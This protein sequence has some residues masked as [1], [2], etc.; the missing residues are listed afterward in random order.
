MY[1]LL[2]DVI[3]EEIEDDDRPQAVDPQLCL[4]LVDERDSFPS[5]VELSFHIGPSCLGQD[6][7]HIRNIPG[8]ELCSSRFIDILTAAS[9][10]FTAY[11]VLLQERN[12]ERPIADRYFFWIPKRISRDEAV[13]WERSEDRI[14]PETSV[15]WL[16]KLVLND[17]F[18]A[19]APALFLTAGRYLVHNALRTQLEAANISGLTFAPLDSAYDPFS[20][21][22]RQE[23]ERFLREHPDD[24]EYWY[25]LSLLSSNQK[26][27]ESLSRTL[28]LNPNF[29]EAWERRGRILCTLGNLE[30]AREAF[31][32]AIELQPQ[33]REK[34]DSM[35]GKAERTAE[36]LANLEFLAQMRAWTQYCTVLRELGR[37][38]EALTI[39]TY[40]VQT[41]DTS[42]LPR[43]ELAAIY[44]ALGRNEEALDAIEQGL[45][46]RGGSRLDD[47]F[48]LKGDTLYQ[49]GRY[50][51]P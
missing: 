12:T 17:K 3:S 37:I 36:Q 15:R 1:S 24:W 22:K 47:L 13:D 18:E 31:Q 43:Y 39:A 48:L 11:P 26:A 44:A 51:G 45:A 20:G 35:P 21:V 40:T 28:E 5:Q 49:S 23:L 4:K 25:K 42:P 32:K 14:D 29:R 6:Y 33:T 30:E 27:L 10:P 9:V 16:T 2:R 7:L 34:Y 41:W 46:R 50:E 38:Q 19:T 8:G